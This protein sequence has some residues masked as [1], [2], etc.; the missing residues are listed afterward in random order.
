MSSPTETVRR[1]AIARGY[2]A[3][4][5]VVS[6][7][8]IGCYYGIAAVPPGSRLRIGIAAPLLFFLPG[9]ALVSVLFPGSDRSGRAESGRVDRSAGI[10]GAERVGL[11]FAVSIAT[12]PL[13]ALVLGMTDSGLAGSSTA[14]AAALAWLT[15]LGA[16]VGAV[17]RLRLPADERYAARPFAW[18]EPL[19]YDRTSG[20]ATLSAVLLLATICATGAVLAFAL[21]SPPAAGEYTELAIYGEDENG[22]DAVG[23]LPDAVAPLE[24]IPLAVE[25]TNREGERRDYTVVI[26]QQRVED[27]TVLDRT[28]LGRMDYRVDDGDSVRNERTVL[29]MA[30]D[31]ETV[32][33]VVLL[34]DADD[35]VPAV[36]TMEDADRDVYFWTHV[37][38]DPDDDGDIIV[39]DI[40]ESDDAAGADDEA[41]GAEDDGPSFFEILVE[42]LTDDEESS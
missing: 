11:S 30:A 25:V 18:F 42:V 14:A 31:G 23:E 6:L 35:G 7:A 28:E 8:A 5:A 20:V 16:V 19:G 17:R 10:D 15:V 12:L 22:D 33:I 34:F 37:T 2:P 27:G 32:R 21:A 26:Q 1:F 41:G 36:P 39:G 38:G 40:G 4:L 3:D 13:L 9:F 29:P 24:G